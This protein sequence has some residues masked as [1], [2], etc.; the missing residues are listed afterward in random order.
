MDK[1]IKRKPRRLLNAMMKNTADENSELIVRVTS[2][3]EDTIESWPAIKVL[4]EMSVNFGLIKDFGKLVKSIKNELRRSKTFYVKKLPIVRGLFKKR[5]NSMKSWN[6]RISRV[7]CVSRTELK[8][9]L[10]VAVNLNV[11]VMNM[12][13]SLDAK[14][15]TYSAL[16]I[17]SKKTYLIARKVAPRGL[18]NKFI[19]SNTVEDGLPGKIW[20]AAIKLK[21]SVLFGPLENFVIS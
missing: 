12:Y 9:M 14:A 2:A 8:K 1:G 21:L 17:E 6:K 20:N 18:A 5:V 7:S 19:V 4:R 3:F 15:C 10:N 11:M 13:N 16:P